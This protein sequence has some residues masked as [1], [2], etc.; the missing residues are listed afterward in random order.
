[1]STTG[2]RGKA[3]PLELRLAKDRRTLTVRFE[4]GEEHALPA[5]FLRVRSPSAEVRGHGPGQGTTVA[6]KRD[7]AIGEIQPVGNY[8]VRLVFD[9]GHATG[10]YGWDYLLDLGRSHPRYW[11]AYLAE[12]AAKGLPREPPAR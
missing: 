8:A 9:D 1:M 6:G 4:S 2:V 3:W 10:I 5:E 11:R 12:V 7:V